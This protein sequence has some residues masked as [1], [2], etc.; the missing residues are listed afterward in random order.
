MGFPIVQGLSSS[1]VSL[2]HAQIQQVFFRVGPTLTTFFFLV[3][4]GREHPN[5][6]ISGP[7]LAAS[8]TPFKW[9]FPGGTMVAQH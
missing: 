4:E 2:L 7:S 3:D 8:K 1:K 6:T 5:T 9:C